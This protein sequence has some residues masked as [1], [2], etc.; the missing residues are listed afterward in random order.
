LVDYHVS[1]LA[2]AKIQHLV[3]CKVLKEW[4]CHV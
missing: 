3:C 1:F 4:L 2:A